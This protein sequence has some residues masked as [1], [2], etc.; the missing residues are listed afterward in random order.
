M[1]GSGAVFEAKF[2][3]PWYFSEEAAV[4]KY[5]PQL[6][7][8]MWVA[9]IG[10]ADDAALWA[11]ANMRAKNGLS[12]ADALRVE[13]A[14]R[15]KLA[16]FAGPTEAPFPRG[17]DAVPD[18]GSVIERVSEGRAD[19]EVRTA[20]GTTAV[21]VNTSGAEQPPSS[22]EP[23]PATRRHRARRTKPTAAID[24]TVLTFPEPRR[25]RDREHV[26]SVAEQACLICG[27]RPSDAHHLRFTQSR[28]LGRKNSDE[29]TVPLCRGHHREVHRYGDEAAWWMKVRIEPIAAARALWLETHPLPA[30]SK[31]T[32][33]E[34]TTSIAVVA[35]D[36]GASKS[37]KETKPIAAADPQ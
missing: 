7:H 6:Q 26:R 23:A 10:S 34:A 8:N 32:A 17:Q 11:Y 14:F 33:V 35:D 9:E 20:L 21:Q 27:R 28:A 29:Y 3:L 22:S 16:G 1:E 15:S 12:A 31:A 18:D 4:E 13:E 19:T 24:K 37:N 2:M 30:I 5:M 36:T 25:I